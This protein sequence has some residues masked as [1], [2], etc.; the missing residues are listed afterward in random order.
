MSKGLRNTLGVAAFIALLVGAVIWGVQDSKARQRERVAFGQEAVSL[1]FTLGP[2]DPKKK[3]NP[4]FDDETVKV[5]GV[6]HT[7]SYIEARVVVRGCTVELSLRRGEKATVTVKGTDLRDRVVQRYVLD[8]GFRNP[9]SKKEVEIEIDP[10]VPAPSPAMVE[11]HLVGKA[12]QFKSCL[13]PP[14][15]ATVN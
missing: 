1:G 4:D 14:A 13:N 3:Y 15:A 11:A 7:V 9:G 10:D 8:E 2:K 6:E 5:A 12:A